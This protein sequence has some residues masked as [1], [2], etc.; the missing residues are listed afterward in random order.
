MLVFN[1]PMEV[2]YSMKSH[3]YIPPCLLKY[4]D[5]TLATFYIENEQHDI[6]LQC[7]GMSLM[8]SYRLQQTNDFVD[9]KFMGPRGS[10]R[11]IL[12]HKDVL[13]DVN[14]VTF[15]NG[16]KACHVTSVKVIQCSSKS[17]K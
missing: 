7:R 15:E 14:L 4:P 3:V 1:I 13:Y 5:I 10:V 6:T 9:N 2:L 8:K 16:S 11:L 17:N 12:D